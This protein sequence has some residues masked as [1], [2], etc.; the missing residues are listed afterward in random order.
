M[1]L[2][3]EFYDSFRDC[4]A[5]ILCIRQSFVFSPTQISNDLSYNSELGI[6][7]APIQYKSE[8]LMFL[9]SQELL[10]KHDDKLCTYTISA[11]V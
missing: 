11:S 10:G 4:I 2:T 1:E 3:K 9:K 7:Y 5:D 6:L 8:M